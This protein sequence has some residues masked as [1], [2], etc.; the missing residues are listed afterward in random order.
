MYNGWY[1]NPD[2]NTKARAIACRYAL[3]TSG[4]ETNII[5]RVLL[6]KYGCA[7]DDFIR[8][9]DFITRQLEAGQVAK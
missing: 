1:P 9:F 6:D 5:L 7:S 4:E 8:E 2:N 3:M